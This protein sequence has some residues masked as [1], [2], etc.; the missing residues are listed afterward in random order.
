M[1]GKWAPENV[2]SLYLPLYIFYFRELSDLPIVRQLSLV[3]ENGE[4]PPGARP[5]KV[6]H[7]E[8]TVT[9]SSQSSQKYVA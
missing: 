6:M 8:D 3:K 7:Q 9:Q 1:S 4:T 5:A 2:L